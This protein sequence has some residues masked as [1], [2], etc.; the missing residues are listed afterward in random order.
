MPHACIKIGG[1]G[2]GQRE[3]GDITVLCT[4]K[5]A[6]TYFSNYVGQNYTDDG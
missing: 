3:G 4:E 1:G 6:K 5:S 2:R